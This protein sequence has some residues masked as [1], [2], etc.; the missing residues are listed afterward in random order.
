MER[1]RERNK[2]NEPLPTAQNEDV[3][4]NEELADEDDLEAMRRAQEADCRQE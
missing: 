2:N 4:F 3:E 1:N